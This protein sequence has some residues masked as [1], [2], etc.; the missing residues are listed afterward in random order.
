MPHQFQ[1]PKEVIR[2][3]SATKHYKVKP[4]QAPSEMRLAQLRSDSVA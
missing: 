3:H 1:I 4:L 2:T